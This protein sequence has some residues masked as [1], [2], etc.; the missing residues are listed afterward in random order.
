MLCYV[1]IA[2]V[3]DAIHL[4]HQVTFAQLT[5]DEQLDTTAPSD[6]VDTI[7]IIERHIASLR[8]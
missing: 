2:I 5:T 8:V 1:L 7:G 4:Q 6:T 3:D